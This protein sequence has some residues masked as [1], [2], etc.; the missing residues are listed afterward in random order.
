MYTEET[1]H[2]ACLFFF[3]IIHS[4]WVSLLFESSN[5]LGSEKLQAHS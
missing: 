4:L 5:I 2:F 1:P 3:T